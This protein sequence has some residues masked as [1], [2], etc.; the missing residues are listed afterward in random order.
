[1][2]KKDTDDPPACVLC[3]QKGHTANYLRCPRAAKR[4]PRPEEDA[5]HRALTRAFSTTLSYA[6]AAA[7]PNSVPL[8]A[9][10]NQSSAEEDLKQL[11]SIIPII[12]NNELRIQIAILGSLML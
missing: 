6:R 11:V 9:K 5:L 12:N 8:T 7:G 1:M 4:A 2:R 10:Q 3:K